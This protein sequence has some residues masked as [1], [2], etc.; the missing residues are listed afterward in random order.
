MAILFGTSM[1]ELDLIEQDMN[2]Y[3]SKAPFIKMFRRI[4]KEPR[5]FLAVNFTRG[6]QPEKMYLDKNFVSV[7]NVEI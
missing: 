6:L 7:A 1:K 2:Y 3:D 4:T 5:S